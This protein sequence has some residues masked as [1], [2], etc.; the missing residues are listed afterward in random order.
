M[1]C[2][3]WWLG[4][5]GAG[6]GLLAAAG[7]TWA[8]PRTASVGFSTPR[9]PLEALPAGLREGAQQVV[10]RVTLSARGPAET[11]PCQPAMYRWLLDHPVEAGRLWRQ[12]GAKVSEVEERGPGR[13]G[14][15]DGKG[16]DVWWTVA[17]RSPALVVLYAEGKMK[18]GRLPPAPVQAL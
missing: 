4:W 17:L 12:L 7:G 13:F 3:R 10:E 16:S 5:P 6:R 8:Q 9:V 15:R 2:R 1:A 14:W 18:P 11:F